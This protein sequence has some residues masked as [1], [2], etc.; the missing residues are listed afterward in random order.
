MKRKSFLLSNY[1]FHHHTSIYSPSFYHIVQHFEQV[2][3]HYNRPD[4]TRCSVRRQLT[5][6]TTS[7]HTITEPGVFC[8]VFHIVLVHALVCVFIYFYSNCS[9]CSFCSLFYFT[10]LS[11]SPSSH[12][13]SHHYSHH[14]SHHHHTIILIIILTIIITIITIISLLLLSQS[15]HPFLAPSKSVVFACGHPQPRAK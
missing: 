10:F 11:F 13:H 14:H 5:L 15:A 8:H 6:N 1:F 12:H 4:Q 3:V 9:S 7:P 2:W